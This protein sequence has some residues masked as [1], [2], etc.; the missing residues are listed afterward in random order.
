[1]LSALRAAFVAAPHLEMVLKPL[2]LRARLE[3]FT[4]TT[5]PALFLLRSLF[6]RPPLV[7]ALVPRNTEL[8]ASLPLAMTDFFIARRRMPFMADFFMPLRIAL[9]IELPFFIIL[10][11]AIVGCCFFPL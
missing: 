9:R 10:R 4:E 1:M 7:F 3:A 6:F 2:L 5:L 11:I 8:F